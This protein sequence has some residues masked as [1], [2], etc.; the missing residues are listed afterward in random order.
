MD[1]IIESGGCSFS[2]FSTEPRQRVIITGCDGCRTLSVHFNNMVAGSTS[3]TCPFFSR[4]RRRSN[5]KQNTHLRRRNSND[6]RRH[7][8]DILKAWYKY[9]SPI[10]WYKFMRSVPDKVLASLCMCH[11]SYVSI[12][13]LIMSPCH[14]RYR[15]ALSDTAIRLSVRL[16]DSYPLGETL[17]LSE[18]NKETHAVSRSHWSACP[19][20]T[21]NGRNGLDLEQFTSSVSS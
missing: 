13:L 21:G 15:G 17:H 5:R 9:K 14:R 11:T 7:Q 19:T 1:A 3:L 8:S 16:S 2:K 10:N 20:T 18:H 4:D 12:I 6:E